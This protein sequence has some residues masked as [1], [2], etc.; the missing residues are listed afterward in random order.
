[1]SS[2]D[3][4]VWS[5]VAGEVDVAAGADD[6]AVEARASGARSLAASSSTSGFSSVFF[7]FG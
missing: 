5:A 2:V 7:S 3:A 1:M 6:V 4:G